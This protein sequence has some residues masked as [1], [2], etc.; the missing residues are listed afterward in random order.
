MMR[1]LGRV[2]I[3]AAVAVAFL[4]DV[5]LLAGWW[6]LPLTV[7]VLGAV[8]GFAVRATWARGQHR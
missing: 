5:W 7:A 4:L 2:V 6:W 1:E 8:L 3:G